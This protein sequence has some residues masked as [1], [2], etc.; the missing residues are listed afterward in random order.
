M[1]QGVRYSESPLYVHFHVGDC[2]VLLGLWWRSMT[3]VNS[4]V[5]YVLE[6][7]T[8]GNIL[9]SLWC[10]SAP[11]PPNKTLFFCFFPLAG[12]HKL[13]VLAW[14]EGWVEDEIEG[15]CSMNG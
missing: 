15:C 11:L 7:E 14:M 4:A 13:K 5:M 3:H 8:C 12:I 1:Y 2:T 10:F 6:G 9:C